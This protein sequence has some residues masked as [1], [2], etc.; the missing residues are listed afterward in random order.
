MQEGGENSAFISFIIGCMNWLKHK[1]GD[2][3]TA[4]LLWLLSGSPIN[5]S[6]LRTFPKIYP[7]KQKSV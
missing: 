7:E 1:E 5:R 6:C 4:Q 2:N 3:P